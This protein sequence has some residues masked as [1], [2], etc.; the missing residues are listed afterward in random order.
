MPRRRSVGAEDLVPV[1][2]PY[3]RLRPLLGAL[4]MC[5]SAPAVQAAD[6]CLVTAP[7]L[8][9]LAADAPLQVEADAATYQASDGRT[10]FEGNAR[11]LQ[12]GRLIEAQHMSYQGSADLLEALGEIRLSQPD[13]L[14]TGSAASYHPQRGDGEVRN[15]GFAL[16]GS[17]A[18][19][20][21]AQVNLAADGLLT[22]RQPSYTTCPPGARA[23]S[24]QAEQ[25]VLDR[26][27]GRGTARGAHLRLGSVDL[28]ALPEFSFPID[29]RRQSGL[30]PPSIGYGSH[31]GLDLTLPYYF[32]LAP[33][34]DLTLAPRLMS[35]RGLLLGGE[36]RYLTQASRGE[37][38]A[39]LL[40]DDRVYDGSTPRGGLRWRHDGRPFTGWRSRVDA[41]YTSDASYLGDLGNG[42]SASATRHLE[43]V[44]ELSRRD[45]HSL[46]LLR[47]QDFQV[48]DTDPTTDRPYARLPQLLASL[49]QPLGG[50]A[51][52][53]LDTEYVHFDREQG[54]TGQRVDIKPVLAMRWSRPWGYLEPRLG[55]RYTG[56][57]LAHA[58]AG[59]DDSPDR[60]S[61]SLSLDGGLFYDRPLQFGG[62]AM[63]QTL[64]PRLYYLYRPYNNQA[65]LPVFDTA[66]FDFRF[67]SL[68]R[69]DRFS[70]PDRVGDANQLTLAVTSRL[71][72][73]DSGAER[74]ALGIGQIFYFGD[75]HVTLPGQTVQD[76]SSSAVMAG[77]SAVIDPRWRL[78]G[79]LQW[80]PDAGSNGQMTRAFARLAW[81]DGQGHR[82]HAGY[83][84]RRGETEQTDLAGSWRLN[85]RTRLVG[86]WRYAL[87]RNRSLDA[88]AGVEYGSCCWKVRAVVQRHLD[89][90]TNDAN[91][92]ILLQ[93]ELSGL[94]R[95][96]TN[97]DDLMSGGLAG[98]RPAPL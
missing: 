65:D 39:E 2:K 47:V 40:P 32:N 88:L 95:L 67:D 24:L 98:Y 35:R 22:L 12:P 79:A 17:G 29:D 46:V 42:L 26:A 53:L 9:T 6:A 60:F 81:D 16:P 45:R 55:A 54:L 75:R 48:L 70:G 44:A 87:D 57:R 64:E 90:V 8:P 34:R 38:H 23:W 77:L 21:A 7:V 63:T 96:G 43:R 73:A 91:L 69:D 14:L 49:D 94:G 31:N 80:D 56:Y 76:S 30:L 18:R 19:G 50:Q 89:D 41:N 10:V 15:A 27:S 58:G 86:R 83:R 85:P 84:L 74:L 3:R 59:M 51:R 25:M 20:E 1:S 71:R 13:L 37:L 92:G 5:L 61:H 68:F 82:L 93:L 11:L 97:I 78:E 33:N 72:R 36:Y 62:Q 52:L 28:P 66:A 4:G